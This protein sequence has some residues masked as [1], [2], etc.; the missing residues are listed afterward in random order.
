[1]SPELKDFREYLSLRLAEY[2]E[3]AF[4]CPN[5]VAVYQKYIQWLDESSDDADFEAKVRA[6]GHMFSIAKAEELDKR[7][8]LLLHQKKFHHERGT[9]A[10]ELRVKA[11]E[12]STDYVSFNKAL[13]A[14]V[15]G[16][17][18][19]D[20][21]EHQCHNAVVTLFG[22]ITAWFTAADKGQALRNVSLAWQEALALD[23]GLSW[24][25]I[26]AH[27][28]YRLRLPLDAERLSR[29]GEV[30]TQAGGR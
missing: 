28:P 12:S 23:Q 22:C 15:E 8:A 16:A 6:D 21:Q 27:P 1:M 10:A 5:S 2:S 11:V 17:G 13:S 30:I 20:S 18:E 25:K 19:L 7:A 24:K 3:V 29:Y 14:Q 9:M 26:V 4:L